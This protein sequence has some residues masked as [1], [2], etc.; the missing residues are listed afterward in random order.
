MYPAGH[1]LELHAW[2]KAYSD[3]PMDGG[4]GGGIGQGEPRP[5]PVTITLPAVASDP[6]SVP[7]ASALLVMVRRVSEAMAVHAAG[8]VE[9]RLLNP[10]FRLASFASL[11]HA[12]GRVPE[13]A[14]CCI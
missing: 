5:D 14:F 9:E 11:D 7:Q 1:V 13:N 10:R 4:D 6:G 3:P 12:A 8:T 2:R